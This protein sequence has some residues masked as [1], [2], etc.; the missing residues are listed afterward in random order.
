MV[1]WWRLN[2]NVIVEMWDLCCFLAKYSGIE[3][4]S[5]HLS[6]LEQFYC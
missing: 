5:L 2:C 1:I 6:M 4:I 3:Y